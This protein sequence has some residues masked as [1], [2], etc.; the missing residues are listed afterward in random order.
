[1]RWYRKVTNA[2]EGD[3]NAL[4]DALEWYDAEYERAAQ[5]LK[6]EGQRVEEVAKK[7][8]GL[9]AYYYGI[10]EEINGIHQ[11][12][13]ILHIRALHKARKGFIEHYNTKLSAQTAEKYA[14]AD[15]E[16]LALRM[17]INEVALRNRLF[18]SITTGL[19][20]VNFRIGDITKLRMAGIEDAT[21]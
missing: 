4:A 2:G 1:M 13:E 8:G 5:D 14:E 10:V 3:F 6:L 20:A 12:L 18:Q 7:I 11:W 15:E 9:M 17:L 16:A 19:T 21:I